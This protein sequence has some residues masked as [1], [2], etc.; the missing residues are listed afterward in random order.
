MNKYTL[1]FIAPG[2]E[3]LYFAW[4]QPA[5]LQFFKIVY[6]LLIMLSLAVAIYVATQVGNLTVVNFIEFLLVLEFTGQYCFIC[7]VKPRYV[8]YF[9]SFTNIQLTLLV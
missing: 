3:Q 2:L 9:L 6:I 5:I 1:K 7:K 8:T 4:R